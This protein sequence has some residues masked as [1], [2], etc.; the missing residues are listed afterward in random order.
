MGYSAEIH[1]FPSVISVLIRGSIL[2]YFLQFHDEP[3]PKGSKQ[4]GSKCRV[5]GKS[6]DEHSV[7]EM[8]C[9]PANKRNSTEIPMCFWQ[10][11]SFINVFGFVQ[12]AYRYVCI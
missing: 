4:S 3:V 10:T 1:L 6:D 7:R 11:Y 5:A 2:P 8:M 9:F 12:F